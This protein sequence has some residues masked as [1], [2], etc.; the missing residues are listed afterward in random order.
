[1]VY[2]E[3]L[4]EAVIMAKKNNDIPS[5]VVKEIV[6][7][8]EKRLEFNK[9]DIV[10]LVGPNNVGKSRTLKDLRGDLN[11]SSKP[12]LL[13]K[14]VKYES[15]GFSEEQLR[16]YFERNITKSSYGGYNVFLD[17]NDS[18]TFN[19]HNFINI[20][21]EKIFYKAMFSFLSTENRLGL[22]K[23]IKFYFEIDKQ[24]LKI[25]EKLDTDSES[26]NSLNKAINLGFQKSVEVYEDYLDGNM[27][28]KYKIGESNE[29]A[30]IIE[31]N[32]RDSLSKLKQFEDLHNQGDGIRNAV[33][34]LASLIVN[35]HSLFL[36]DEPETFLHP[37][38]AKIL[39]K[40]I[41][42]LSTDKQ[43]FISTHNIDF[44]RG[45]LEEDSSRVKIIKIDRHDNDNTFSLINNDS[46]SDISNDK[47]LKYTNILNGL[48]YNQV[49]LCENESDCKFYSAILEYEESVIYQNS[50]FCAVG[51]KEQFKKIVPLLKEL[52][53]EYKIIADIDLISNRES[54]KQLLSS[55]ESQCYK[56]IEEQHKQFLES[57]EM[58][59]NSQVKTQ[60]MIKNEIKQVFNDEKYMSP[61]AAERIKTILRDVS[62]LKLLKSGGKNIIP[63]GEWVA[64][65]NEIKEFLTEHNVFILECGEIERLVPEIKGH[66][67]TWVEKT[68]TKYRDIDNDVYD[69]AR[70]FISNIFK[71]N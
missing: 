28:K 10:L 40:N 52:N 17:D 42:R 54:L 53:I 49:I 41:V 30:S 37:P 23:P 33:A 15:T 69:K 32:K 19:D 64:L 31:S 65:F 14:D 5:I 47:N 61:Q 21:N 36:I 51:G 56:K 13:V 57:F 6:F 48:F 63:Q 9:D 46:I 8:N 2:N 22:T 1:M 66:G 59:M 58:E 39:G 11:E 24:N 43:V 27:V 26:I 18:F 20:E 38:Q 4:R 16:D 35:E 34:I 12:K 7:N 29:I 70:R 62:S 44:I 55:I 68:F 25:M 50:L 67:N 71:K 60:E 45:V 3:V